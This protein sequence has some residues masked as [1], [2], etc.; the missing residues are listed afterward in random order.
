MLL[1]QRIIIK[2]KFKKKDNQLQFIFNESHRRF[3]AANTFAVLKLP[4]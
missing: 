1:A 4:Y 3:K 2:Y